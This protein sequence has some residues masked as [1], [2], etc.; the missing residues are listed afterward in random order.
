MDNR[1]IDRLNQLNK[2]FYQ[3]VATDFNFSRNYYWQG[4]QQVLKVIKNNFGDKEIPVL[5]VGCGNG[6]FASFL[7]EGKT[8]FR[9][10]GLDSS[11][12]LL[13]LA[14]KQVSLKTKTNF[15]YFDIV[16]RLKN[17]QFET[18]FKEKNMNDPFDL[19]VSFGVL[20]HIPSFNLRKSFFHSLADSLNKNGILVITAWQF[21]D[22]PKLKERLIEFDKVG[23]HKNDVEE[24]DYLLDW[25]RG[26]Q[27]IR[28]CHL[29][30]KKE[31]SELIKETNL[32]IIEMYKADSKTN[33]L[34][35]YYILK[36][37]K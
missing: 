19:I 13:N 37:G 6:R 17:N 11:Q 8:N 10:Y 2:Q 30:T 4:W 28:Y 34:N 18:F 31:I 32:K 1:T 22:N 20:H 15:L 16:D 29:T 36:K 25:R 26:E 27:A 21:L 5:D 24:N 33:N 14:S 35:Q 12:K 3:S 9:Y 7:E 23:I